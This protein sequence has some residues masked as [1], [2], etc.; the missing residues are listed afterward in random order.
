MKTHSF[1]LLCFTLLVSACSNDS[2]LTEESAFLA[3]DQHSGAHIAFVQYLAETDEFAVGISFQNDKTWEEW[4]KKGFKHCGKIIYEEEYEFRRTHV[5]QF[6]AKEWLDLRFVSD[7]HLY[8][9]NNND[10]GKATFVRYEFIER[11]LSSDFVAVVK[12]NVSP[13]KVS[14]A[15]G[16]LGADL[17]KIPMDRKPRN[18]LLDSARADAL[19][20]GMEEDATIQIGIGNHYF[21]VFQ[22]AH[23]VDYMSFTT[24]YETTSNRTEMV[25]PSLENEVIEV[26][27]PLPLSYK[28]KPVL[29][30]AGGIRNSDVS[31][32][33]V[34]VFNGEKYTYVHDWGK[35]GKDCD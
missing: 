6:I 29:L 28:G 32:E 9:K 21:S 26:I 12:L 14:Y 33:G 13:K 1:F 22:A 34:Y 35:L 24:I 11:N 19:S 25:M 30:I 27:Q 5:P 7:F 18:K 20:A 16:G 10:L 3:L 17:P 23:P 31:G 4:Y 15:I 2:K 8:D